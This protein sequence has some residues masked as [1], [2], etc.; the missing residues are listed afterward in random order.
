M[1]AVRSMSERI[2]GSYDDA[3][4]KLT[5]TLLTYFTLTIYTS[6]DVFQRKDVPLGS[7]SYCSQFWAAWGI[8]APFNA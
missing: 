1:A 6:C 8:R 4:Y 7:R 5:Y 3:L 2:R